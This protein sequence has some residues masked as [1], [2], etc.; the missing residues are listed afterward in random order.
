[1]QE[2]VFALKKENV[3]RVN[4]SADDLEDLDLNEEYHD[5]QGITSLS[6]KATL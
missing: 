4:S 6:I 1:M 2:A 3:L 5:F